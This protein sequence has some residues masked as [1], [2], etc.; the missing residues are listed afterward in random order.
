MT[1]PH[2]CSR[3]PWTTREA[4]NTFIADT[5]TCLGHFVLNWTKAAKSTS[6]SPL[7]AGSYN[8][9]L[10]DLK[11]VLLLSKRNGLRPFERFRVRQF[12]SD[13]FVKAELRQPRILEIGGFSTP[14]AVTTYARGATLADIWRERA[15]SICSGKTG[16]DL[17]QR[18]LVQLGASLRNI[19]YK[20]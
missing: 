15:K 20:T 7:G 9:A 4:V 2:E 19:A 1:L 13:S 12:V 17:F 6:L 8:W 5:L 14:F 18:S 11:F 3:Y 16:P 10:S